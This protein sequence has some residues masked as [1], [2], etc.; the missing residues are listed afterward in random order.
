MLRPTLSRRAAVG[1]IA[2]VAVASLALAGGA[3]AAP[4]RSSLARAVPHDVTT[5]TAFAVTKI[6][7]AIPLNAGGSAALIEVTN[8]SSTLTLDVGN[9]FVAAGYDAAG[10]VIAT[11]SPST[12]NVSEL[13]DSVPPGGVGLLE[14]DFTVPGINHVGVT[15]ADGAL[16]T[17]LPNRFNLVGTPTVTTDSIGGLNVT[18]SVSNPSPFTETSKI[19]ILGFDAAGNLTGEDFAYADDVASGATGTFNGLY[20]LSNGETTPASY[21]YIPIGEADPGHET[22]LPTPVSTNGTAYQGSTIHAYPTLYGAG[23]PLAGKTVEAFFRVIGQAPVLAGSGVTNSSGKADIKLT[24]PGPRE[25]FFEF[26]GDPS[27]Y[28]V[29]TGDLAQEVAPQLTLNKFVHKGKTV[30]YKH[31]SKVAFTGQFAH[32]GGEKVDLQEFINRHWRTIA[33]SGALHGT[34]VFTMHIKA[35][36]KKGSYQ[37]RLH[38]SGNV[39]HDEG[40]SSAVTLK[41]T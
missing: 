23:S 18:G 39:L 27:W 16:S 41:V 32:P 24:I 21:A 6:S 8:T 33:K 28:G 20:D 14:A 10:N 7:R 4:A 31:G 26:A 17:N 35:P 1:G 12:K 3:S 22:D 5:D 40:T 36:S 11:A 19:L 2:V 37:F 38:V 15:N 34:G 9:D 25:I 30:T 29:T 13:S